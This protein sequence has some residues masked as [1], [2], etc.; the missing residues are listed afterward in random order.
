MSPKYYCNLCNYS[1]S[2][3]NSYKIHLNSKLHISKNYDIKIN[4]DIP[5]IFIIHYT[6]LVER[7][8]NIIKQLKNSNLEAEFI[9]QYDRDILTLDDIK[10]FVI[11]Y[12][13]LV[14]KELDIIKQLKNNTQYL[15][16]TSANNPNRLNLSK[17]SLIKKHLF[18]YQEIVS[19]YNFALILEDDVIFDS[20]FG[21]KL[22]KYIHELPEN[23]D[24]LF[25][26]D[27]C[28]N[29]ISGDRIKSDIHIYLKDNKNG[30]AKCTDSYLITKKCAATILKYISI[31][32]IIID[33]PCDHWLDG[34]ILE[35]D[36]KVY[37]AEPTI[38]TQG[39]H[40]NTFRTSL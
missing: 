10:I 16:D 31:P 9:T 26:G 4:K 32:G 33:K 34:L 30:P 3:Y 1:T 38:V 12:I 18:C 27:C 17:I 21:C 11:H 37:W 29:H 8:L 20:D 35:N 13:T 39:S 2:V 40:N 7:K 28:D 22:N 25:V 5:K 36:F 19:K 23:W 6:P 24:M 14:E 15:I